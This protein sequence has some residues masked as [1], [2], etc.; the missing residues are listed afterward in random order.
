MSK[1]A[2]VVLDS[3]AYAGRSN[4]LWLMPYVSLTSL[5]LPP[6]QYTH[7]TQITKTLTEHVS[8]YAQVVLDSCAYAGTGNVLKVQELLGLCGEHIETEEATTWKVCGGHRFCF[9]RPEAGVGVCAGQW[10]LLALGR[11]RGLYLLG[12]N[13]AFVCA[14][15]WVSLIVVAVGLGQ[16]CELLGLCGEHI[17]TE[18]ATA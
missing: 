5:L 12:Q 14:G 3:G 18:E 16:S 17:K 4:V 7:T 9:C 8:K 1:S 13:W 6:P 2:Q 11:I 10:W 15:L